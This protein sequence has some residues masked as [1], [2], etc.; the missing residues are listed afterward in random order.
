[1]KT[2]EERAKEFVD[3]MPLSCAM[4]RS[5]IEEQL[6]IAF[7]REQKITRSECLENVKKM[8]LTSYDRE[9]F[10]RTIMNTWSV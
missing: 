10:R 1:M 6:V 4:F 7:K 3:K 5:E 9:I 8:N 2:I